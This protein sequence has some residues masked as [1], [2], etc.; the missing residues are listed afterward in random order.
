ME[1]LED[2]EEDVEEIEDEA[3]EEDDHRRALR[4]LWHRIDSAA[5]SETGDWPPLHPI[6]RSRRMRRWRGD[7]GGPL[8]RRQSLVICLYSFHRINR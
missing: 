1:E 8:W 2:E 5:D 4:H 3:E 6:P 7:A